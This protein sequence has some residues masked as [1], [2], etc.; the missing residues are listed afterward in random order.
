MSCTGATICAPPAFTNSPGMPHTTAVASASAM[1]RPPSCFSR[2]IAAAPSL[3]MPVISTPTRLAAG[4]WRSAVVTS[5]STLGCQRCSAEAGAG[6][7]T[8][9]PGR[10]LT[11]MSASPRAMNTR[12]GTRAIG[13]V[14]SS[15][16]SAHRPFSRRA[17]EAVKVAGMCWATTT[18]QGKSAGS[19]V[20]TA[21][22]AGG[23]PVE[24][25]IST[26]LWP[27]PP[28]KPPLLATPPPLEG[29]GGGR[30]PSGT[31]P[32][33]LLDE[34]PV[35]AAATPPLTPPLR[36][37][38]LGSLVPGGS[39]SRPWARRRTRSI[40]RVA[41]FRRA[42]AVLRSLSRKA[43]RNSS[44]AR[45]IVPAGLAMK[46]IAPSSSAPK[47]TPAP[48]SVIE[49]S[50]ST[51]QGRSSMMRSRHASPSIPGICTSN[52]TTSGW[53]LCSFAIAS[54][55]SRANS[56]VMPGSA[57][58]MPP[59][60]RRIRAESSTTR[61][62]VTRLDGPRQSRPASP[63][64]PGRAGLPGRSAGSCRPRPPVPPG[65][66]CLF[67]RRIRGLAAGGPRRQLGSR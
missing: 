7:T 17:R 1:V 43:G 48:A 38:G 15:T 32:D 42:E 62:L 55:P 61:T 31:N 11:M 50:I 40:S 14:T 29:G 28:G 47:V 30:G 22:R 24:V 45:E 54:C 26:T 10:W 6:I 13:C 52:V 41:G 35:R 66:T 39:V 51:R 36:G 16:S 53:K 44:S 63:V 60:A 20:S 8:G 56:T 64:R 49:E 3:P 5:R 33:G 18:G 37:G 59:K 2:V 67:A 19:A 27:A 58:R 57:A 21:S 4:R 25:P 12:P 46:S 34:G 65:R 23:P 9:P